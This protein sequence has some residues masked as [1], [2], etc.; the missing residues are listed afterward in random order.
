MGL[1]SIYFFSFGC[2]MKYNGRRGKNK[3]IT[4]P[5]TSS[6]KAERGRPTYGV[7]VITKVKKAVGKSGLSRTRRPLDY[8]RKCMVHILSHLKS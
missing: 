1:L 7:D 5:W 4:S 6:R 3:F 2:A 8:I